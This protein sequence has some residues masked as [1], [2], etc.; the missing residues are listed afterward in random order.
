[1]QVRRLRKGKLAIRKFDP[2]AVLKFSSVF[3]LCMLLIGLFGL[4]IIFAALKAFG[5]VGSLE[6]LLRNLQFDVN[7]SGWTIFRWAFLIGLG[8]SIIATAITTF[9]AFLYNLIADVVGGIEMQV[10][11]REQ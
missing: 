9:M 5:V 11:E 7:I 1:M 4:G 3:Y 10:T 6:K 8:L 2:W